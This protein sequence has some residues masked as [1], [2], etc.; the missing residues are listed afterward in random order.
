MIYKCKNCDGNMVYKIEEQRMFCPYCNSLDTEQIVTDEDMYTCVCC[1]APIT[2]G[3]Y[4]SA[5]KCKSCSQYVIFDE[6]IEGEYKPKQILPFKVSKAAAKTLIRREYEKKLYAPDSFLSEANLE[7]IEGTYV[8]FWLFNFHSNFHFEGKGSRVRKWTSGNREYTETS[9]YNVCRDFD[10]VFS[11]LP[12]DASLAMPDDIMDLMEPYDYRFLEDFDPKYMSGFLGEIYNSPAAAYE[13]RAM[14]KMRDDV[15]GLF[16]KST[17]GYT[18][19]LALEKKLTST[20]KDV[21][22]AL[23]PVWKYTYSYRGKNYEYYING[24]SGKVIG[25][26]PVSKIKTVMYPLTVFGLTV[27]GISLLM[28]I[29]GGMM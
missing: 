21:M 14:M 11:K 29:F 5:G 20:T 13:P 4:E 6:R 27:I 10:A 15:D 28:S 18:N 19:L 24:Q 1:G 25:E 12:V 22:Y 9:N 2:V 17:M 26:A 7:K 16:K 23:L 3:E 8:P